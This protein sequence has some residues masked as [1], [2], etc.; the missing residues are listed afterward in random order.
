MLK[1]LVYEN[2][3]SQNENY[4]MYEAAKQGH[5]YVVICDTARGVNNDYSAVVVVDVPLP[6]P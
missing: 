1:R 5:M 3:I 2:P 6:P 4:R